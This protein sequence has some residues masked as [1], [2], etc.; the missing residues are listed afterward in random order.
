M[1]SYLRYLR[2]TWTVTCGI[3]CLLLCVLWVRSYWGCDDLMVPGIKI[4]TL[5]VKSFRGR[6]TWHL[7]V[8][9]QLHKLD[10]QVGPTVDDFDWTDYDNYIGNWRWITVGGRTSESL[11]LPHWVFAALPA[12]FATVPWIRWRFTLRTLL[13]ATTLVAVVLGLVVYFSTKP[14]A[15][16]PLDHVDVPEF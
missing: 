9:P 8:D 11:V 6:L 14:P 15:T 5:Q 12:V 2:I 16:P 1:P 4:Q 13:I 7:F 3:A 10:L